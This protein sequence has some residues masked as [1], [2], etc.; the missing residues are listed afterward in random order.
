[1]GNFNVSAMGRKKPCPPIRYF[2]CLKNKA[3]NNFASPLSVVDSEECRAY[4][5]AHPN[6]KEE[7]YD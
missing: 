1:M 4:L 7:D 6:I 5:M 3:I 2:I